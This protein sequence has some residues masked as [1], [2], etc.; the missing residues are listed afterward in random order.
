MKSAHKQYPLILSGQSFVNAQKV[1][2]LLY[3]IPRTGW[4]DRNVI[5]PET[6]GEHTD[7]LVTLAERLFNIPGLG[8]MLKI[9]D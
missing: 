5:N 4:V 7:E 3:Q 1:I 8:K 2:D 6:V 9:H